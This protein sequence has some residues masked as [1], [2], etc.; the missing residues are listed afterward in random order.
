M[1]FL[2]I[3]IP[4][5]NSEKHITRCLNSILSQQERDYEIIVQDGCSSDRTI[6]LISEAS[7]SDPSVRIRIA[8]ESDK[9]IYDAMNKG[10]ERA[11]GQ[12]VYFLGSDDCLFDPT[13]LTKVK[14]AANENDCDVIYGSIYNETLKVIYDGEFNYE[15]ICKDGICHQSIIYKADLLRNY[16]GYR[17]EMKAYAH[18][19]LDKILFSIPS[20]R[21]K[22]INEV[23]ANYSGT[24]FSTSYFDKAYWDEA[25]ALLNQNYSN[26]VSKKVIYQSLQPIVDYQF[27]FKSLLLSFKIAYFSRSLYPVRQWLRHP[28]SMPRLILKKYLS[29]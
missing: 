23:I 27:S 6:Q 16:G 14:N 4:T 2:S 3:I 29:K 12:W 1:T 22:Y 19:Y 15:K 10:L 24:G 26:K 21:W 28:L 8:N 11:T 25:E 20:V 7:N 18:I 17:I 9:G 13:V 5:F